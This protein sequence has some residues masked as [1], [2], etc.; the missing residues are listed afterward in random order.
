MIPWELCKRLHFD[1]N[2]K[3]YMHKPE[4][5][6][7]NVTLNSQALLHTNRPL[8]TSQKTRPCAN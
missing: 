6:Q 7:K 2:T 3:W 1:D 8:K 4:S 5:D